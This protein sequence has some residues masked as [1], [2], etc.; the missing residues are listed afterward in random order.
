MKKAKNRIVNR[1]LLFRNGIVRLVIVAA[2]LVL[3]GW[4]MVSLLLGLNAYFEYVN[5]ILRIAAVVL[6]IAIYG[7]NKN[8]EMKIPW[9]VLIAV[10]PLTGTA[11]YI[12]LGLTSSAKRM[13]RR[14]EKLESELK[15][16]LPD[17]TAEK[18]RLHEKNSR[19]GMISSYLSRYS[20]YPLHD[21]SETTYFSAASTALLD[22]IEELKKA[23]KYIFMEYFAIEDAN[24]FSRVL[25]VLKK[26]VEEGVEVRILYD[27]VGSISF[28]NTRFIKKMK[29]YGIQCRVYN[30]FTPFFNWFLNYRDHRKIMVIDGKVAYTGGY[31]LADRYFNIVHPYGHWKDTGVRIRGRAAQNFTASFLEMWDGVR[32]RGKQVES[33]PY[34]FYFPPVSGDDS[35]EGMFVQPFVD[36]PIDNEQVS[37]NLYIQII[38]SSVNYVYFMTPYLVISDEMKNALTLAAKRGVD[39]RIITPGIPD[40]N[41][42]YRVTRSYYHSLVEAGIK[43][44]EY[45]PGFIHAKCCVSD[46]VIAECG[47]FN[48]DFRSLYQCFEDGCAF[49]DCQA[50]LDVKKDFLETFDKCENVS[51]KYKKDAAPLVIAERAILRILSPLM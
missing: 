20:G 27:D 10:M 24:A 18:N 33:R 28:I 30:P 22:Q 14:Y 8:S 23:K 39:V 43:V 44:Y 51:D 26:K 47:T 41:L 34:D 31:N 21:D 4:F 17:D 49:Y 42:V 1:S 13:R 9:I 15:P 45:T 3:E 38:D 46:D 19:L 16:Y 25:A 32:V 48:M 5:L 40:K 50:V 6:A 29:S 35:S 37:E 11:L 2:V 36:S 12:V 7:Q